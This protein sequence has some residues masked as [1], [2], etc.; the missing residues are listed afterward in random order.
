MFLK[1]VTWVDRA[2][3][4]SPLRDEIPDSVQGLLPSPLERVHRLPGG[5]ISGSGD[6]CAAVVVVSG[7]RRVEASWQ[8]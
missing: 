8:E 3:E 2:G 6:F 5:L 1:I 4:M 7:G